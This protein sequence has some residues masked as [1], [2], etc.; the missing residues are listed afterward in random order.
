M[1]GGGGCTKRDCIRY[2]RWTRVPLVQSCVTTLY[3]MHCT[4]DRLPPTAALLVVSAMTISEG[5]ASARGGKPGGGASCGVV[6]TCGAAARSCG[7]WWI[8]PVLPGG[9]VIG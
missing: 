9:R 2:W 7:E 1:V 8:N 5:G 3:H 6:T 4:T